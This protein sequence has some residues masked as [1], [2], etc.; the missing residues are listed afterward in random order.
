MPGVT[1]AR[2]IPD[3]AELFR[4]VRSLVRPGATTASLQKCPTLLGLA[5]VGAKAASD[6]AADRAAAASGVIAEAAVAVD[7]S[8]NGAT[9]VLLAVARGWR[10]SLVKDRRAKV[11]EML[12]LTA[13]HFR[14]ERERPLLLALSDRIFVMDAAHRLRHRHRDRP[15]PES[16]LRVDWL[17]QHRAYRRI[18][19]P[20]YAMRA[21]LLVLLG[22]LRDGETEEADIIDRLVNLSWRYA[23]FLRELERFV[24]VEGGV[25]LLSDLDAEETV[26]DALYGIGYH[27]PFGDADDSWLRLLLKQSAG[28]ELEPFADQLMATGDRCKLLLDAWR[29]WA[30]SCNLRPDDDDPRCEVH[31]WLASATTFLDLIDEDWRKVADWYHAAGPGL[32]LSPQKESPS[33]PEGEAV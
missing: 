12:D 8:K 22:Y 18:W 29:G 15:P 23:Q 11:A 19:T 30:R 25:W 10:G 33:D 24:E 1:D 9:A 13:D 2:L 28:E 20:V 7:G 27:V 32:S 6:S 14:E 3:D 17:A 21:D 5:V 16:S 26:A 4:E 31:A